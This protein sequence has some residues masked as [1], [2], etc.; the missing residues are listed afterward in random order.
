MAGIYPASGPFRE[1][2][3]YKVRLKYDE[4]IGPW[5]KPEPD[6]KRGDVV[7]VDLVGDPHGIM[8]VQWLVIAGTDHPLDWDECEIL[9]ED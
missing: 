8:A 2:R 5:D 4:Y 9:E 1:R 3:P 7:E 6:Y